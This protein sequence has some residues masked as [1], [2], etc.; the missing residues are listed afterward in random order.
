MDTW[1]FKRLSLTVGERWEYLAANID[2]EVA[3][4]GRFVPQRSVPNIDCN[5]IKGMGC[6]KDWTPRVGFVY[7]VFGNHKTAIK[8]GFGKFDSQYSSGFTANFNPMGLV[9]EGITSWNTTGLGPNCTPVNFPGLG[10]GPNPLCFATG[11]FAPQGTPTSAIPAGGLGPSP[12]PNFGLISA[13]GTGVALDPN[14]HRDYN[15]Q[16]SAGVQQELFRGVTLNVNWFRRSIYQGALL[17]NQNALPLSDWT[18]FTINNPLNGTPVTMYNLNSSITSLPAASLYET[19]VP[20][21]LV[22]DT[23]T[24]FEFQGVGRLKGGIFATFGYTVE[25]QLLRNC[26][27]GLTSVS[28]TLVNPNGL[29]YCD[30]F[31]SSSLTADGINVS[32]LGAVS[33]PWANNFVGNI[34]APIRWG[35]KASA[36]FISNNYQGSFGDADNGYLPRTIAIASKTSSVYPNGCVGCQ[37]ALT[38]GE[39]C[40]SNPITVACPIDPGYNTLQGS[41]T[42][43]LVPPGAYRSPRVNQL[44]ISFK[45][46]FRIRERWILE[47]TIQWFNLLNSNAAISQTTSIP[48]TT[49][50]TGTAPFLTPAQCVGSTVASIPQCGLGGNISTITTPRL[51]KLALTIKF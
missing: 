41:T 43:Q 26:A 1:K 14:W 34:V 31:G 5:T 28:A 4:A 19:N 2:P 20:Q 44:D 47:P 27:L 21:S 50:G 30:Q 36:S 46:T 7:D 18:P 49:T 29:R 24:G 45:R 22:R 39:T 11:G 16:Y 3:P 38:S 9:S 13:G 15:Y 40:A 10:P 8:A 23:Y 51:M 17:L 12:N 33:P 37:N 32:Q 25:R 42:V 6:W 35:V 48:V